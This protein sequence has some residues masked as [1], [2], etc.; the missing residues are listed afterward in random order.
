[1]PLSKPST[2]WARGI[3]KLLRKHLHIKLIKRRFSNKVHVYAPSTREG[4]TKPLPSKSTKKAKPTKKSKPEKKLHPVNS[5]GVQASLPCRSLLEELS[6]EGNLDIMSYL[7]NL[8][9]TNTNNSVDY[10]QAQTV[11]SKGRVK[12][13]SK[14]VNLC[15][16]LVVIFFFFFFGFH[17]YYH[18]L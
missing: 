16:V 9:N 6:H 1:M 13:S 17:L 11:T 14:L 5:V 7:E 18:T 8:G 12:S 4:S 10:H 15:S 3:A 2:D